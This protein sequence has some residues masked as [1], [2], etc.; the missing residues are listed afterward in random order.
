MD[1]H[2]PQ[3]HPAAHSM[4]TSWFAVDQAGHVAI[5]DSGEDGAVPF[6]ALSLG[7]AC[8]ADPE[9]KQVCELLAPQLVDDDGWEEL[10]EAGP[11]FHYVNGDYGN[12]GHYLRTAHTPAQPARVA[13]LPEALRSKML[14]LPIDFTSAESLHLAEF[15]ADEEAATYGETTL[16]GEP[17]AS[18]VSA[19]GSAARRSGVGWLVM[20]VLALGLALLAGLL[21]GS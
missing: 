12:P 21:S 20:I 4:D 8:A 10:Y 1:L 5:F 7:G 6:A 15:M 11:F 3:E 19:R 14:R 9:A 13:A 18:P 2:E 16:R 17:L